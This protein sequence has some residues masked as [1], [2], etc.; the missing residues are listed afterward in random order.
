M[1][2]MSNDNRTPA[3]IPTGGEF[4]K[5]TR[6]DALINLPHTVGTEDA[7]SEKYE[8]IRPP[9]G[10]WLWE[11]GELNGTDPNRVWTVVDGDGNAQSIIT[12]QHRVNPVGYLVTQENWTDANEEFTIRAG[13]EDGDPVEAEI[14][15]VKLIV[16][17][18]GEGNG[19]GEDLYSVDVFIKGHQVPEA[20]ASEGWVLVPGASRCTN[21]TTEQNYGGLENAVWGIARKLNDSI[22]GLDEKAALASSREAAKQLSEMT[23]TDVED[24]DPNAVDDVDASDPDVEW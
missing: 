2:V 6:D 24:F 1:K 10:E 17:S 7:W 15:N 12:G 8:E 18:V 19:D 4:A 3:G 11:E 21:I 9:S 14:G 5:H 22:T 13:R 20:A 16:A 23:D